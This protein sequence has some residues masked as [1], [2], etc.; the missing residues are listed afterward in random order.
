MMLRRRFLLQAV[1]PA[2]A[3]RRGLGSDVAEPVRTL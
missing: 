1:P 2:I 3:V